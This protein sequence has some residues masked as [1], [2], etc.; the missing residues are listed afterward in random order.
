MLDVY[1]VALCFTRSSTFCAFQ[2]MESWEFGAI[3]C[4]AACALQLGSALCW[5]PS[6]NYSVPD[7]Q[8]RAQRVH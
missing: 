5:L 3:S 4:Q 2:M 6:R 1:V 7:L 8:P